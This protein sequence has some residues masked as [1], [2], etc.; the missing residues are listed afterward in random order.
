MSLSNKKY[1]DY[2]GLK[3]Y[4]NQIKNWTTEQIEEKIRIA[5]QGLMHIKTTVSKSED[6]PLR[7][8]V[9]DVYISTAYFDYYESPVEPG[10]LF[11]YT[12]IGWTIVQGNID[13]NLIENMIPTRT[14]DLDND[15]GYITDSDLNTIDDEDINSLF[16]I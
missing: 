9:G 7:P 2:E 13:L 1:L 8:E 12:N 14:S 15:A 3:T 10:D 16:G 11:V 5:L 4:N 6:I